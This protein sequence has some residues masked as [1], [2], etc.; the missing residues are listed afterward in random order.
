M[1]D[2]ALGH[3]PRIDAG[4]GEHGCAA[5]FFLRHWSD[6]T[7]VSVPDPQ[8]LADVER[9]VPGTSI[10]LEVQPG[11]RLS[12]LPD[13]DSYSYE[14]GHIYVGASDERELRTKFDACERLVAV[15]LAEERTP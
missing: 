11:D 3:R 14:L 2:L 10:H 8:E 12:R 6:A 9:A 15:G 7:V 5:K 4:G 13:Q 1:V